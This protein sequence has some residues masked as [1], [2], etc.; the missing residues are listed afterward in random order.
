MDW[1]LQ[2]AAVI[3]C[4]NEAENIRNLVAGVKRF[5]P[6]VIVVDD[7]STDGTARTAVMGGAEVVSLGRNSGKGAALRAGWNRLRQR[8]FQ[9][10]LML[11][12]DGQHSSDDIPIFFDSAEETGAKLIVGRRNFDKVPRLRRLV[13]RLLSWQISKLA[14]A[15]LPD[16]QCGFRLVE[17]AA[18]ANL[19]LAA[20]HFEIE[21]EMLVA[22]LAVGEDVEFVPIQTIYKNGTSHIRPLADTWRWMRWSMATKAVGT[23]ILSGRKPD[24]E[25]N[26]FLAK[27]P[28]IP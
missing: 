15:D 25:R 11:D 7:G 6:T 12:G 17:L 10:T 23:P 13:N 28:I 8:N 20:N 9:W 27:K 22:F 1:T 4:F 16:S 18:L 14:G 21:S 2:C 5:L 26:H 3:P 24:F 19:P